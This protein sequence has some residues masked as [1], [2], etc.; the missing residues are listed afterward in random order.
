MKLKMKLKMNVMMNF[1]M[2][3]RINLKM[4]LKMKSNMR[5]KMNLQ[6]KMKNMKDVLRTRNVISTLPLIGNVNTCIYVIFCSSFHDMT[7]SAVDYIGDIYIYM[8]GHVYFVVVPKNH[9]PR[10]WSPKIIWKLKWS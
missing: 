8:Y 6:M 1:K 3:V 9:G 4:N 10:R 2:V 5:L 7:N